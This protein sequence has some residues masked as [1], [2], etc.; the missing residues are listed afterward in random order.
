MARRVLGGYLLALGPTWRISAPPQSS[1]FFNRC[2]LCSHHWLL[3]YHL[4]IFSFLSCSAHI[5]AGAAKIRTT[6]HLLRGPVSPFSRGALPDMGRSSGDTEVGHRVC[7]N[8]S[9]MLKALL[10]ARPPS[11]SGICPK[12]SWWSA[13]FLKVSFSSTSPLKKKNVFC[14]ARGVVMWTIFK[15]FMEFVTILFW[16]YVL[17][18]GHEA[19]RILAPQ[20][21]IKPAVPALKGEVLTTKARKV[22][23]SSPF[24]FCP[25]PTWARSPWRARGRAISHWILNVTRN[26]FPEVVKVQNFKA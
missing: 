12:G 11:S 4:S 13:V 16:F 9:W 8:R 10:W 1:R 2:L 5:G 21:G 14:G 7:W 24:D 6:H 23:S 3:G 17:G 25:L 26:S 20:P 22:L 18:F 19:C 15:V